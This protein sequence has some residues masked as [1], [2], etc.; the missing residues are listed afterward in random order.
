M[1][2]KPNFQEMNIKELRNYV[3]NHRDDEEAFF[4]YMDLLHQDKNRVTNPPLTSVEDLANYPDLLQK[5][6]QEI[7]QKSP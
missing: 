7:N 5:F 2:T 6:S 4:A 1:N 3:L